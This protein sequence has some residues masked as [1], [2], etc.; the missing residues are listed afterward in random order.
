MKMG[1]SHFDG[2]QYQYE[3]CWDSEYYD[4]D[5]GWL[6]MPMNSMADAEADLGYSIIVPDAVEGYDPPQIY[7]EDNDLFG[8]DENEPEVIV[9]NREL[10]IVRYRV[11]DM[12]LETREDYVMEGGGQNWHTYY[13]YL[14]VIKKAGEEPVDHYFEHSVYDEK[15]QL[16][17]EAYFPELTCVT[18]E[19]PSTFTVECHGREGLISFAEWQHDGFAYAIS[20]QYKPLSEEEMKELIYQIW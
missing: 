10:L 7:V 5:I 4:R 15:S 6:I 12:E 1:K 18:G 9:S 17:M 11:P 14:Q 16:E 19:E 13:N 20:T 8:I 3:E 2:Q